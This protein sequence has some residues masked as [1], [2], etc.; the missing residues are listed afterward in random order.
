M[1]FPP[2]R[3]EPQASR[4]LR[5][6]WRFANAAVRNSHDQKADNSCKLITTSLLRL[7]SGNTGESNDPTDR[8]A[9]A[10]IHTCMRTSS[11]VWSGGC[12][13]TKNSPTSPPSGSPATSACCCCC[14]C[15]VRTLAQG[16]C[17]TTYRLTS[18]ATAHGTGRLGACHTAGGATGALPVGTMHA[19]RGHKSGRSAWTVQRP[20]ISSPQHSR[21]PASTC[22]DTG[23]TGLWVRRHGQPSSSGQSKAERLLHATPAEPHPHA[24]GPGHPQS[25][26]SVGVSPTSLQKLWA[27][28]SGDIL[29]PV[30][31]RQASFRRSVGVHACRRAELAPAHGG[32]I[33]RRRQ[34]FGVGSGIRLDIV[35]TG[36]G[37]ESRGRECA[38][39]ANDC[40][41][42]WTGGV[43]DRGPAAG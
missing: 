10:G 38:G 41:P 40:W 18:S 12:L 7:T 26:S 23:P 11:R 5:G 16:A 13:G 33:G 1:S 19:G 37:R 6:R 2:G 25:H 42:C 8:R 28:P 22:R 14:C 27:P 20:K 31:C 43:W 9:H 36:L 17:S 39:P 24:D 15:K 30:V 29:D 4:Q 34:A 35:L 21:G 3:M 32:G